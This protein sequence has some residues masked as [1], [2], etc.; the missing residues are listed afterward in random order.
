M[1]NPN[2]IR[3]GNRAAFNSRRTPQL[4]DIM[5]RIS[6]NNLP[7][8]L[9]QVPF[10]VKITADL[11]PALLIPKNP[12]RQSFIISLV[13]TSVP[14][15]GSYDAPLLVGAQQPAGLAFASPSQWQESNGSISMNDLYVWT[16]NSGASFPQWFIGYEGRLSVTG[17]AR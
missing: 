7:P 15:G 4:G 8:Q 11:T 17:N 6:A 2:D 14:W 1:S 5:D 13:S 9:V 10:V 12:N 16:I 3:S